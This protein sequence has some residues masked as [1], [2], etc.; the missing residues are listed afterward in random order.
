MKFSLPIGAAN[1]IRNR[2]IIKREEKGIPNDLIPMKTFSLQKNF[3]PSWSEYKVVRQGEREKYRREWQKSLGDFLRMPW[4]KMGSCPHSPFHQFNAQ[5]FFFFFSFLPWKC[6][7]LDPTSQ[8]SPRSSDPLDEIIPR[9][10]KPRKRTRTTLRKVLSGLVALCTVHT[11]WCMIPIDDFHVRTLCR[12]VSKW[13]YRLSGIQWNWGGERER[14]FFSS[15][16]SFF[17]FELSKNFYE[18]WTLIQVVEA[19]LR[20]SSWDP[21]TI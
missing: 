9:R 15:F 19:A 14:N 7:V 5:K 16:F 8:K 1:I 12:L 17:F 13:I 4:K 21:Y 2:K 20:F 10:G 3:S 6:W 11:D 18:A